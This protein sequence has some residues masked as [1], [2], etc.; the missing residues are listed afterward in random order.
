M[1]FLGN[2]LQP[3]ALLIYQSPMPFTPNRLEE[4]WS[5]IQPLI[6]KEW[7]L[8]TE[9]DLE[10]VDGRFDRLVEIVRQRYGGRVEIIQEAAIRNTLNCLLQQIEASS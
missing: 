10:I 4:N 7:S 9:S 8:L 1:K 2:H 5:R 3:E 6:L